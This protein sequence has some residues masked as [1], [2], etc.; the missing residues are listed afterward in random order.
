MS[1]EIIFKKN[2]FTLSEVLITIVIIGIIAAI[3][4]PELN[5]NI[6]KKDLESRF[7]KAYSGLNQF[8]EKFFFNE[9]ISFTEY[10]SRTAGASGAVGTCLNKFISYYN[11]SGYASKDTW[12][13]Q[14]ENLDNKYSLKNISGTQPKVFGYCDNT[15]FVSDLSGTLYKFNDPPLLYN[16][17]VVCVDVNGIK[18]PNRIGFDYFLFVFTKDNRVIPM[19][20]DDKNNPPDGQTDG[21]GMEFSKECSKT[22]NIGWGCAY[23]ALKNIHPQNKSKTY[24]GD[25]L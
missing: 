11:T 13:T 22:G 10:C 14:T 4:I 7:L 2:G 3:T 24:W 1:R 6:M 12:N 23:F 15:G 9:G 18:G 20:T 8:S 5:Q 17:P 16:G 19:G 21:S 25:F